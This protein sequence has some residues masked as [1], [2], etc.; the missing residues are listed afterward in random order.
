MLLDIDYH[1]INVPPQMYNI[2]IH[3]CIHTHT[4]AGGGVDSLID[5]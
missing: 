3:T 4:N 5:S 2:H 1:L